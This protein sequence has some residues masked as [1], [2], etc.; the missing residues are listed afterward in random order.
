MWRNRAAEKK[1]RHDG[2][3]AH[4][5]ALVP[6]ALDEKQWP[7]RSERLEYE[8]EP[9]GTWCTNPA[10]GRVGCELLLG[11]GK[12]VVCVCVVGGGGG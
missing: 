8:S 3:G 2:R 12:C 4:S 6:R 9:E 5:H 1:A 7:V 10:V 11:I